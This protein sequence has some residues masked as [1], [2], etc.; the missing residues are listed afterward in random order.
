MHDLPTQLALG[1][2]FF[3]LL[4]TGGICRYA[5]QHYTRLPEESG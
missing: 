5:S 1:G 3:Y 2:G 4:V